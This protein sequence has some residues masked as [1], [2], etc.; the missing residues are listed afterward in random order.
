MSDILSTLPGESGPYLAAVLAALSLPLDCKVT[1]DLAFRTCTGWGPSGGFPY[2]VAP[3]PLCWF[4]LVLGFVLGIVFASCCIFFVW[5]LVTLV[6]KLCL[7]RHTDQHATERQLAN[8][9]PNMPDLT[10]DLLKVL[11]E[12]LRQE[13]NARV[14]CFD[15]LLDVVLIMNV[16]RHARLADIHDVTQAARDIR[17]HARR[18]SARLRDASLS[19]DARLELLQLLVQGGNELLSALARERGVVPVEFLRQ[20]AGFRP[21]VGSTCGTSSV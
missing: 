14:A 5:L 17:V 8:P 12:N 9:R 21:G 2:G 11:V 13:T 4:W 19:D 10:P 3:V 6:R 7:L 15:D 20:T 18:E 16:M 1:S